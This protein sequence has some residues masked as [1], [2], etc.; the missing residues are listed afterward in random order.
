MKRILLATDFSTRSDRAL[1]RA[2]LLAR[3]F[4][5]ELILLHVVDDDQPAHLVEVNRTEAMTLLEEVARTLREVDAIAGKPRIVLGDPFQGIVEVTERLDADLV[6][7]GPHRRQVLRDVFAGTTAERTIRYGQRP[8]LVA[9]AVPA[10]PYRSVV[11]AL[12]FTD[13]S[14]HAAKTAREL[15]LLEGAKATALHVFDPPAQ[16]PILRSGV[17]MQQ[18]KDYLAEEEARAKQ[19]LMEFLRKS[20][21]G[22]MQ[23]VVELAKASTATTINAYAAHAGTDLVV[24]GTGGGTGIR[25]WLLGSVAA[26]VLAYSDVDVLAVPLPRKEADN[27]GAG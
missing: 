14:A 1:R 16:G 26:E 9:N 22:P 24:V 12:D 18:F 23:S 4:N 15:G 10:G 6:V 19:K 11:L 3:Q 8:V 2:T 20:G 27:E 5:A 13:H 25:K 7:V 17:T 21:L